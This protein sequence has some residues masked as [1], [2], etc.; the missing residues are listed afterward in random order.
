MNGTRSTSTVKRSLL[1]YAEFVISANVGI[2]P[3]F[4]LKSEF[5]LIQHTASSLIERLLHQIYPETNSV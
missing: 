2:D 4:K 3:T 5:I 1:R